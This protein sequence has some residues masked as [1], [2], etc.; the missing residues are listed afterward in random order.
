MYI[1]FFSTWN[2]TNFR[3]LKFF[4]GDVRSKC[5][6]SY[7][8][9]CGT[10]KRL[11]QWREQKFYVGGI[12]WIKIYYF[13]LFWWTRYPKSSHIWRL[14][15][16]LTGSREDISTDHHHSPATALRGYAYIDRTNKRSSFKST[17]FY[18]LIPEIFLKIKPLNTAYTDV[19]YQYSIIHTFIYKIT[20]HIV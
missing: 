8:H 19:L 11:K 16:N 1:H 6:T 12:S 13:T 3:R 2:H 14:K 4:L 20:R 7:N 17:H 18:T 10:L 9:L 5:L 15:K